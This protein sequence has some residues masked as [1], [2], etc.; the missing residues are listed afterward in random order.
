MVDKKVLSLAVVAIL[1]VAGL[2][3]FAV[4]GNNGGSDDNTDFAGMEIKVADNLD[5][6][7]VAVGQDSFRWVT[8]FGLADKCVMVDMN[9]KTN[10]M[11]KAFMYVGKAQALSAHPD[12]KFTSTNCGV[13]PDDVKTIINLDPSIV[14]VPADFES[15]YPQEMDSLRAAGLNI[16][17]IGYIYTF[18]EEETFKITSD[19]EKQ[20]DTMAKVLKKEERGEEL[21]NLINNTVS[22][23][24][25]IRSGITEARTGYIGALA[26][27]GAH[28]L[29]SSINYYMP[30]ALAGIENIME[31]AVGGV[32]ENSKVGTFSATSIK[33][34]IQADTVLFI[35]GTGIYTC[36]TNTDKGIMDLFSGHEA[37]V[38]CPYIWTG[39]NY[40]NVLVGA[41][42]ILHDVYGLLTD[43]ELKQKVDAVYEG[44]LG[45]SDSL[46]N[47]TAS[48]VPVSE[49][50]IS[51]YDDMNR[52]YE[53]RRGNPIHG[54]ISVSGDTGIAYL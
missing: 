28:G 23:I 14:I 4:M 41:Y 13:I 37:Y 51:V 48:G 22:D 25:S 24:L 31:D 40:E 21:K 33:E 43:E 54:A 19:L 26:Y 35:D 17:H 38:A 49:T 15:K 52:L 6:G 10:Y 11:G 45:S 29:D 42:Q 1:V 8:Y 16:F 47:E 53:V 36:T 12:L 34:R 30:F 7:I 32:D 39:M 27:N 18:L 5:K 46:R 20:I 44:F 9:D 3:A 50:T 2:S